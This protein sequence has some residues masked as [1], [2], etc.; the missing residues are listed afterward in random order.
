MAL[1]AINM[2]QASYFTLDGTL[3]GITFV[4]ENTGNALLTSDGWVVTFWWKQNDTDPAYRAL[5]LA[6]FLDKGDTSEYDVGNYGQFLYASGNAFLGAATTDCYIAI[7]IMQLDATELAKLSFG[8]DAEA[9]TVGT[10]SGTDANS[11]KVQALWDQ[12]GDDANFFEGTGK[13]G[14]G[15]TVNTGALDSWFGFARNTPVN[16]KT[17]SIPEPSTWLLLGA[18]AAF[19][20]V[21][22]RRRKN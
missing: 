18:S 6:G 16:V 14:G 13:A 15:G 12:F 11:L 22:R 1:V 9:I 2:S 19:A 5:G 3:Q 10:Q 21:M 17:D 20:V 4:D 7:G 8:F